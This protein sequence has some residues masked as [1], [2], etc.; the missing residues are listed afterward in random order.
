[1]EYYRNNIL[2]HD[3]NKPWQ[4]KERAVCILLGC[5]WNIHPHYILNKGE[6]VVAEMPPLGS[7]V[8][9]DVRDIVF[10]YGL[11]M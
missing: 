1:M 4:S 5:I 7:Q 6:L 8:E 2:V 10:T 9:I 11:S 3:H